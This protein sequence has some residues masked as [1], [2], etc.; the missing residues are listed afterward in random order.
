MMERLDALC[1]EAKCNNQNELEGAELR[2]ADYLR[3]KAAIDSIEQ[4]ILETGE[5]VTIADSPAIWGTAEKLYR[6]EFLGPR[7]LRIDGW[8]G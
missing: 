2:S 8:T 4:E 7:V 5:G 1:L 6:R 3:I